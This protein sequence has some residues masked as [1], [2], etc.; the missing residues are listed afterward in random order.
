M[1]ENILTWIYLVNAV[2]LINQE[3]D[4]AYWKEWELFKMKGGVTGFLL[5]HLSRGKHRRGA[6]AYL[7]PWQRSCLVLGAADGQRLHGTGL[8]AG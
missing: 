2:F 6:L 5:I 8:V 7:R 4:S 1:N 3:M